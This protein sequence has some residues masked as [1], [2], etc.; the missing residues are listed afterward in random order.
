MFFQQLHNNKEQ[1][2]A[3]ELIEHGIQELLLANMAY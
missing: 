3:F 1:K 2:I